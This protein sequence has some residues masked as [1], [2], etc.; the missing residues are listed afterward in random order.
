[1]LARIAANNG[2]IERGAGGE[3]GRMITV[4]ELKSEVRLHYL[5]NFNQRRFREAVDHGVETA[6]A[7]CDTNHIARS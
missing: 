1:M 2:A 7:W 6:R 3:F 5:F 4:R